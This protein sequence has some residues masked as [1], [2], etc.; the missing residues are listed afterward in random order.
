VFL[1]RDKFC[2]L[3]YIVSIK[4]WVS[5]ILRIESLLTF[6]AVIAIITRFFFN[7]SVYLSNCY[8]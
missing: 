1:T 5:N 3:D 6:L 8:L 4:D 2:N 7:Y